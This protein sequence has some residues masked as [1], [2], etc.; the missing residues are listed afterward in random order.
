MKYA[1]DVDLKRTGNDLTGNSFLDIATFDPNNPASPEFVQQNLVTYPVGFSAAYQSL[2]DTAAYGGTNLGPNGYLQARNAVEL[3]DALRAAI[4]DIQ[5]R[6]GSAA[7][8]TATTSFLSQGDQVFQVT[9]NSA[10]WSGRL[11][12]FEIESNPTSPNFGEIITPPLWDAANLISTF[13]NRKIFTV[14]KNGAGD[15]G[16]E[17]L[18]GNLTPTQQGYFFAAGA[19]ILDPGDISDAQDLLNYVLG[20]Q[21]NEI[22]ETGSERFRTRLSLLPDIVHSDPVFAAEQDFGYQFENY[23]AFLATKAS[24]DS[25]VYVGS[26]GGLIHGFFAPSKV[27]TSPGSG[28]FNLPT[29]AGEERI[30]F[31]PKSIISELPELAEPNYLH[32]YYVDGKSVIVDARGRLRTGGPTQWLSVL[33]S[34]MG[35][36]AEGLFAL[37]VTDP[38]QFSDLPNNADDLFLWEV[39]DQFPIDTVSGDPI[40]PD[41]GHLLDRASVIRVQLND[42]SDKWY[43]ITG[44]GVYS[45][46]GKAV[47]YAISLDDETDQITIELDDGSAY[48]LPKD[49]NGNG[50][51]SNTAVDI[52]S[53]DY[54]DRVYLSDVQGNIWRLDWDQ[55]NDTFTNIFNVGGHKPLFRSEVSAGVAGAGTPQ[56]LSS[57]V[58]V[59]RFPGDTDALIVYFGAGKYYEVADNLPGPNFPVQ[60]FYGVVDN[61]NNGEITKADLQ[62]QTVIAQTANAR[63]VSDNDVDY[64][65]GRLGWYLDLPENG[66]RVIFE[67]FLLRDRILFTTI[68]PNP[69]VAVDLCLTGA[70]GWVMELDSLTGGSPPDVVFDISGDGDFDAA[71]TL[72]VG[73]VM[74][75]AA[76]FKPTSRG[77][78]L[79]PSF[80]RVEPVGGADGE[81]AGFV[82][83]TEGNITRIT[84]PSSTTRASWRRL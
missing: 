11:L 20:D 60:S 77:A 52:D 69:S 48:P 22:G 14:G 59:R 34:G 40:Y 38:S 10:D 17:F 84:N 72:T 27:E 47:F 55:A 64:F 19:D 36:G 29:G 26:N 43:V 32:R 66:E 75:N 28:I 56:N 50:V 68:I 79:P 83:D 57:A 23:D 67:P 54:V 1:F 80:V 46:E 4:I 78:P 2:S 82:G 70:E 33:V 74:V 65:G 45:D 12:S 81:L 42:G 35:A 21:S 16:T 51:V 7:A 24:R 9:Y 44:N 18:W 71:D 15:I 30:A 3:T 62:P 31:A 73:S 49:Q 39:N 13:P 6:T 25:M 53:D 61:G 41:M 8:A 63:A 76:G 37:N 5:D 58:E